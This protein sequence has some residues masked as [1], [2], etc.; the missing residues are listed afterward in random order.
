ML[1]ESIELVNSCYKNISKI[2]I[3]NNEDTNTK[4]TVKRNKANALKPKRILKKADVQKTE[5]AKKEDALNAEAVIRETFKNAFDKIDKSKTVEENINSFL[6]EIGLDKTAPYIFKSFLAGTFVKK[7]NYE[8]IL[9]ELKKDAKNITEDGIK[10]ELRKKFDEYISKY[11]DLKVK[12][13]KIS[14]INFI[15]I[16]VKTLREK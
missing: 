15:K 11:T 13:P 4:T 12:Y 10:A 3:D 1:E 6:D 9:L 14:I 2:T 7:I 5:K 16:F 8:S